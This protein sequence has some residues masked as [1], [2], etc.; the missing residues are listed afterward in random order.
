MKR[1]NPYAYVLTL[2]SSKE[3]RTNV[4]DNIIPYL[5]PGRFEI[6][7]AV[8]AR[9]NELELFREKHPDVQ[10]IRFMDPEDDDLRTRKALIY[11][12][13]TILV[14]VRNRGRDN[15]IFFEDDAV[16]L[17]MFYDNLWEA[18]DQTPS[19]WDVLKLHCCRQPLNPIKKIRVAEYPNSFDGS[20]YGTDAII[21]SKSGITK[22][23]N[24]LFNAQFRGI[25]SLVHDAGIRMG[26]I[27]G[28]YVNN[29]ICAHQHGFLK[30]T[31]IGRLYGY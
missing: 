19:G 24:I 31:R 16:L 12:L 23:A 9:T 5:E 22:V 27:K 21:F 13:Y 26:K 28:Y 14:D 6:F 25:D 1:E 20:F 4:S 17:P 30:T 15:F 3:R 7:P 11:A 29:T 18:V 8:D 10:R 2:L